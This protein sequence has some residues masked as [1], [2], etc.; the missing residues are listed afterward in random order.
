MHSRKGRTTGAVLNEA[1]VRSM[2]LRDSKLRELGQALDVRAEARMLGVGP[3]TIRRI[4]RWDTWCWVGE[5]GPGATAADWQQPASAV[6]VGASKERFLQLAAAEGL[7]P[8]GA[9]LAR[10]HVEATKAERPTRLLQELDNLVDT[11]SAGVVDSPDSG[12][13]PPT[14]EEQA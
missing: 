10:L 12:N 3:E 1:A 8:E 11:H 6:A 2:R 4:L 9:G 5:E 7:L 14:D 13:P